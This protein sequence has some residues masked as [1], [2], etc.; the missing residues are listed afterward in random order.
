MML[1]PNLFRPNQLF[2]NRSPFSGSKPTVM[3]FIPNMGTLVTPLVS[4]LLIWLQKYDN[5]ILYPFP[6]YF[7][8]VSWARNYCAKEFLKYPCDY[9]WF[10]DAD[11]IPPVNA[12]ELLLEPG[13]EMISGVTYTLKRDIDG[14]LKRVAMTLKKAPEGQIGY[15]EYV[16]QGV[17]EIDACGMSC[18]LIHRKIFESINPPW[19]TLGNWEDE[20]R[21]ED[22]RFCELVKKAGFKIY[23]HFG[24]VCG[25]QKTVII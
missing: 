18:C 14:K 5:L 11:T 9:L 3:L 12:L 2:Q 6:Q 19:F 8:P 20:V 16:G 21:G 13:V 22:F 7:Q 25:H 23:A 10:V 24:V 17:E 1:G 4:N 15:V